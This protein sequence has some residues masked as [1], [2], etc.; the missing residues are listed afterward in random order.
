MVGIT[1]D[2]LKA[3]NQWSTMSFLSLIDETKV[4]LCVTDLKRTSYMEDPEF[5]SRVEEVIFSDSN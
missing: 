2:E 3:S 5:C 4:K 1:D